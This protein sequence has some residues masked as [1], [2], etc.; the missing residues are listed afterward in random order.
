MYIITLIVQRDAI[1]LEQFENWHFLRGYNFWTHDLI[2]ILK[3]SI[4][5]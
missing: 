4:R 5:P 2:L 1:R 3:T